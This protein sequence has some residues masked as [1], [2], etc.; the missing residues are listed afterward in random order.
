MCRSDALRAKHFGIS[1][2]LLSYFQFNEARRSEEIIERLR[3]GGK[4]ALRQVLIN[5]LGNAIKFT[6]QGRV[7][8]RVTALD[9]RS[10]RREEALTGFLE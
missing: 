8:L 9:P 1:K 10:S 5:L 6:Q 4:I 2:P 3:R 7:V